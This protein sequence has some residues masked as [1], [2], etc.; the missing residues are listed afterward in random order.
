M[1]L[2]WAGVIHSVHCSMMVRRVKIWSM[3]PLPAQKP[4]CSSRSFWFTAS[5]ILPSSTLHRALL[6]T[7]SNVIPLQLSQYDKSPFLGN[8]MMIPF[9]QSSGIASCL[10]IFWNRSVRTLVDRSRSA[11]SISAI[12]LSKPGALL[13]LKALIAVLTSAGDGGSVFVTSCMTC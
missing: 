13:F 9:C 1:K 2:M 6:G 11:F 7:D 5:S 10:Q 3:H 8:L 4:A 12:M